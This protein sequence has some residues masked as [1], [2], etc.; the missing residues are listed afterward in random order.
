NHFLAN[1]KAEYATN[2]NT[3]NFYDDSKSLTELK[4]K[5]GYA[6][7]YD[8]NSQTLQASLKN[9]EV[10]YQ[11]FFKKR[12]AFPRFHSKRNKQCL[13]IPQHFKVEDGKLFI[14]KLKEG[15]EMVLHREL[16]AK[17]TCLFI[18]KTA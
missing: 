6:W 2:K 8:I 7:L 15:I 12:A 4:Q 13:K 10:S 11:N 1:R 3:L 9:L 5:E 18:S 16:P 17:P 14:P